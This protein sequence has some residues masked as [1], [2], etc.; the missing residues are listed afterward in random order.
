LV[1]E[2][3]YVDIPATQDDVGTKGTNYD[4]IDYGYDS[5]GRRN[6]KVSGGGTITRTIF[7][8]RNFPLET[9]T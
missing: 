9:W 6:K 4:Q 7:D 2:R 3:T 8:T 1:W 5:M